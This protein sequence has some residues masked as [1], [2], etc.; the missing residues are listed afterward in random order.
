M[1]QRIALTT[2]KQRRGTAPEV[3][4]D[5]ARRGNARSLYLHV[6]F[7]EHKCHYCDF[8]SIVD[9]RDR[10]EP[11]VERLLRELRAQAPHAAPL[12]TIFVG[13]GT[14]SLLRVPLWHRLFGALRD[15][16]DLSAIDAGRGEFSVE[17]NPETVTP[18]LAETLAAGGVNR[19]SMGAQSFDAR[20]LRTLERLHT[21]GAVPR[22]VET[23]RAAGIA[24]VS[25]DLIFA[26]PGQTLADWS[27]DLDAALAL[28]TRHLSAYSLTY[29]PN[30]AMTAR[31]ERGEFEPA[32]EAVELEMLELAIE[33]TRAAGLARYEVSNFAAPRSECR[34]NLAYWRGED[35]LACGPSASGHLLGWRWKNTPRLETYLDS[36]E[37]GLAPAVDIEPPD[38]VRAVAERLMTGLRLAEGLDL[39]D[40]LRSAEAAAPGSST[41]LA[42]AIEDLRRRGLAEPEVVSP[43]RLILADTG[44]RFADGIAAD[45]MTLLR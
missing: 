19:V 5:S 2:P 34:H 1:P 7:C 16:F 18:E 13:G 15:L 43:G 25:A 30:T 26:I 23:L 10:Q 17:C 27:R 44:L 21:P 32:D 33:R 39:D 24:E 31:L 22:A 12:S 29:E 11:F 14:P 37:A 36:D 3:L 20:H 28:G 40:T 9:R 8:Y 38:P 6:P 45:L 35:W 42:A 41:R 4:A